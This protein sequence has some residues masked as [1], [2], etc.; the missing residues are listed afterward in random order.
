MPE[1][2]IVNIHNSKQLELIFLCGIAKTR[3][4]PVKYLCSVLW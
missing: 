4:S 3:E 2:V 1:A